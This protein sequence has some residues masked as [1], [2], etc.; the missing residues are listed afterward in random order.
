MDHDLVEPRTLLTS[1]L[2]SN[3]NPAYST[4]CTPAHS[5]TYL[6]DY[7]YD[8]YDMRRDAL[9]REGSIR[10]LHFEVYFTNFLGEHYT[11]YIPNVEIEFELY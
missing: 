10:S 5:S 11:N 7:S 2:L 4:F 1:G 6:P 9:L 3:L 8:V